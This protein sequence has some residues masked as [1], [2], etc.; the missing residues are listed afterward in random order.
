MRDKILEIAYE[1]LEN[2]RESGNSIAASCPFHESDNPE[3]YS[4]TF[5]MSLT[6]GLWH[7]FSCKEGGHLGQFLEKLGT[8]KGL[9][10]RQYGPLLKS[11]RENSERVSAKAKKISSR[12]IDEAIIG[13]FDYCPTDLLELG[14]LE[15]TLRYFEIGYDTKNDRVTFPIRNRNGVLVGFNSRMPPWSRTR[16]KL[17]DKE[18]RLW[19]QPEQPPLVKDDLLWNL[20]RALLKAIVLG[21]PLVVVEGHKACMWVHQAGVES[22]VASMGS[23]LTET[24]IQILVETGLPIILMYDNDRAG[25][26]GTYYSGRELA[27]Y[28]NLKI[29]KYEE[30]QP[31]RLTTFGVWE[32]LDKAEPFALWLATYNEWKKLNVKPQQSQSSNR[33][34]SSTEQTGNW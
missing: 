6:T 2:I 10:Q 33:K 14:F 17:Y 32:A 31:D 1:Y 25:I 27:K 29:A 12:P 22:V 5:S 4:V 34:L 28:C 30:Q 13:L 9:V 3:G 15:S 16:Y 21:S 19:D 23:S 8:S 24:Q 26:L 11:I 7:C 20:H 18:Y